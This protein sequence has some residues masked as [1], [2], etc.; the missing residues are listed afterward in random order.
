MHIE[1]S[2]YVVGLQSVRGTDRITEWKCKDVDNRR[3][4]SLCSIMMVLH[5][6]I[7]F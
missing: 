7:S 1:D 6:F 3:S 2:R 5:L 4:Q